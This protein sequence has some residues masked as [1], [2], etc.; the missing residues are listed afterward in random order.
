ML[1]DARY[2]TVA[3]RV[4]LA[5]DYDPQPPFGRID[6]ANVPLPPRL[7]RGAIGLAAPLIAAKPKRLTRA[8]RRAHPGAPSAITS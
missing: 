4:Q 3:R 1:A 6:W 7:L 2:L 5:L 8:D